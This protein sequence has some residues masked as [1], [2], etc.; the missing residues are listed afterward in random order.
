VSTGN[1][2]ALPDNAM[3]ACASCGAARGTKTKGWANVTR[4]GAVVGFTCPECPTDEEPIRLEA[5]GRFLV[6]T[7]VRRQDGTRKKYKGRFA[8]LSD[9]REWVVEVRE[10]AA[11]VTA[12]DNDPRKLTVRQL[13]DRWLA[14]REAEVGTPGGIRACS[15][16][17][18]RSS[19]SSL[20]D[21]LGDRRARE[22]TPDDVEAALLTL[23]SV[24][25]KRGRKLS[26][27]SLVYALGA[28][29]QVFAYGLRSKW[30]KSSPAA[31]AKA[32]GQSHANST[33]ANVKALK[34][35]TPAQLMAFRAY[36]DT[37]PL[38]AEPWLRVGMRLTL[39]GL[40]RSEVLGLDWSNVDMKTGAVR[41]VAS[42]T[43]DGRSNTSTIN[44][45]KTENSRR[46]VQAETIHPGTAAAL[47]TLWLAQGRPEAGL[48]IR[49]AAEDPV[50]PDAYSRRFVTLCEA[51]GVPA[52][53]RIHNT[54]HSLASA[55][56]EAG[57][58]D[59][60]AA[61]LLGHD[62]ATYT[63]FYLVVDDDGAAV[64]AQVAGRLF[65]VV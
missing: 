46:T 45:P 37:L 49:D 56:K 47:R 54:R 19:L 21:L 29:R 12:Y 52:L 60:Q 5:S 9:A 13:A 15:L 3:K 2:K 48:V 63:R 33:A 27:R 39:C 51:A 34:R 36:V 4:A 41:I 43:K 18:Y 7:W 38:A 14:K 24:G 50:Q 6:E 22:V 62:V 23:A 31:E 59:N 28:L 16:N 1:R 64:A 65:A 20:L 53:T 35:W 8:E 57:V 10:D 25:G 42:R 58:P 32:P 17:G 26:H 55:L 61:A 30:L 11:K 40:R 44:E